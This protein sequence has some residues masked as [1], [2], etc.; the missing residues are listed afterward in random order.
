MNIVTVTANVRSSKA[1]VDGSHKTIELG[2][3]AAISKGEAWE[4]AQ[5]ALYTALGGQIKALWGNGVAKAHPDSIG[6]AQPVALPA[7]AQAPAHHC[8]AHDAPYKRY[9]KEGKSWY[10]HKGPDGKWCREK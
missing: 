10:A 8:A 2:A 3:E 4:E 1:L 7:S 6:T 9:E 5:A